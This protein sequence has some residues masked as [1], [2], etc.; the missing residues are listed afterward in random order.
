MA[1]E[2]QTSANYNIDLVLDSLVYDQENVHGH[3]L[4]SFRKYS[5]LGGGLPCSEHQLTHYPEFT[6]RLGPS[7]P[8]DLRSRRTQSAR[9]SSQDSLTGVT[10]PSVSER[11]GPVE[12]EFEWR[13]EGGSI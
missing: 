8:R 10:V 4:V 9:C 12:G 6:D 11:L 5:V 13:D 1:H 3:G 2:V 7:K